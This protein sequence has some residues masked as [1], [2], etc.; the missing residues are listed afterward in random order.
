MEQV[1][2]RTSEKA[3]HCN[4]PMLLLPPETSAAVAPLA[5][6]G[7]HLPHWTLVLEVQ[8]SCAL[9]ASLQCASCVAPVLHDAGGLAAARRWSV[10]SPSA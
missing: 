6:R 7:W 3:T 9:R 2:M 8:Q 10:C 4:E 1:D 5:L